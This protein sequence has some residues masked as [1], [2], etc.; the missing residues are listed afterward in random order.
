MGT[1]LG[2][3]LLLFL[4]AYTLYASV[5]DSFF[6]AGST[7]GKQVG[8]GLAVGFLVIGGI[9]ALRQMNKPTNVDFLI[10]TDSEMKKVNW[11]SRKELIGSSKVV[12]IFMAL[13]AFYLFLNDVIFGYLMYYMDVLKVKPFAG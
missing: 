8:V 5:P 13:I 3:S 7:T 10:A 6:A 11:T 9:I 4:L 1:L 2:V 12:I